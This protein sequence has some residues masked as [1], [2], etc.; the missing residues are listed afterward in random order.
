MATFSNTAS[1]KNAKKSDN[2]TYVGNSYCTQWC[3]EKCKEI[4]ANGG[5][6]FYKKVVERGQVKYYVYSF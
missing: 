5:N 4:V 3:K 6:A 1:K 2:H